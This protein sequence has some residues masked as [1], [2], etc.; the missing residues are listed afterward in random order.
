MSVSDAVQ[1]QLEGA[2]A[3]ELVGPGD[4]GYATAR[5][6]WNGMVDRRPA[7]IA[8]CAGEGDVVLALEAAREHGLAVAVRGG[9]TMS[10]AT[11][12]ATAVW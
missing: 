1:R 8:R 3:G 10:R 2:F 4:G 12:C 11:G 9:G 6:V 7:L 5:R